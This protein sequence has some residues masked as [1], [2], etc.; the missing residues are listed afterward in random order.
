M[1]KRVSQL[2]GMDIYTE[3][4]EYVGKVE[5]VILNLENAEVMRLSLKSF[6]AHTLPS[7]DV[8]KII[9]E[10]SVGYNDIIRVGDIII[11]KK[12]PRKEGKPAR[13]TLK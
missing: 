4:A 2:Y 8:R 3:K 11:C 1:S 12:N 6:R 5:D 13:K 7:D 10:E 9:Q